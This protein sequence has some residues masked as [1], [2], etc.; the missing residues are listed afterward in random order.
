MFS[1]VLK[2]IN[3]SNT[4]LS[5]SIIGFMKFKCIFGI[6]FSGIVDYTAL[7]YLMFKSLI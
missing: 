3:F 1:F 7:K 2:I 5:E 4:I 6:I